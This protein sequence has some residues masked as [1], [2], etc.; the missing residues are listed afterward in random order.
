MSEGHTIPLRV[1]HGSCHVST[2]DPHTPMIAR[3]SLRRYRDR[4]RTI[5]LRNSS[6]APSLRSH[7]DPRCPAAFVCPGIGQT[8]VG[9]WRGHGEIIHGHREEVAVSGKRFSGAATEFYVSISSL[10]DGVIGNAI[11]ICVARVAFCCGV[12]SNEVEEWLG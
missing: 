7:L 4:R 6:T 12:G 5:C 9:R 1:L 2:S 8:S 3:S 10:T 11:V